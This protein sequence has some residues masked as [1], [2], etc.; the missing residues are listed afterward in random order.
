MA[1]KTIAKRPASN[2][3]P[4]EGPPPSASARAA[5]KK[6]A[7]VTQ[8]RSMKTAPTIAKLKKPAASS[9]V[10][11]EPSGASAASVKPA[12][13]R[14]SR[15]VKAK[16]AASKVRHSGLFKKLE[17]EGGKA[18]KEAAKR[19][20]KH[21]GR[22]T[23][24]RPTEG[25]LSTLEI[26]KVGS[27]SETHYVQQASAFVDWMVQQEP[28][29]CPLSGHEAG[30]CLLEYLDELFF[31]GAEAADGS[32]L[33]A[34]LNHLLPELKGDTVMQARLRGAIASWGKHAPGQTRV[35][36]PK[37][38]VFALLGA[39]I[40]RKKIRSALAA[41]TS[42][43]TCGRPGECLSLTG[44]CISSGRDNMGRPCVG[45]LFHPADAGTPGKTGETDES[46]VLDMPEMQWLG[47]NLL[48][49]KDMQPKNSKLFDLSQEELSRDFFNGLRDLKVADLGLSPYSLRHSGASNDYLNKIRP[50]LDIKM[51][52]RW[53]S[54]SSLK[55][56]TKPAFLLKMEE[57]LP[58][59]V[60]V[61]GKYMETNIA[62]ILDGKNPTP[63]LP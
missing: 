8:T 38:L 21:G 56:Y 52:G 57:K 15:S 3:L 27:P 11:V 62:D 59:P 63:Q 58:D 51:R 36:M 47:R 2:S 33:K 60:V 49:L 23:E 9:L 37:A 17:K 18:Q 46:V 55:R 44:D 29:L 20:A 32:K 50:L 54:D 1:P 10:A 39:M 53:K 12:Q 13:L 16:P 42:F 28:P 26:I 41:A 31:Q 45:I 48:L 34:A 40:H 61:F 14:T 6:P 35:G 43:Y 30:L 24:T 4:V 5:A 22:K 19:L 25:G 7:T